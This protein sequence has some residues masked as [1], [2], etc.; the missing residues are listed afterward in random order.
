M[1]SID[2]HG[3]PTRGAPSSRAGTELALDRAMIRG[4]LAFS[5]LVG[6][7]HL[8]WRNRGWRRA[9][10]LIAE[11]RAERA[12]VPWSRRVMTTAIAGFTILYMA[13]QAAPVVRYKGAV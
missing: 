1:R 3:D 2:G 7:I 6:P 11:R 13:L 8:R 10:G 9:R 12:D 4:F 5:E